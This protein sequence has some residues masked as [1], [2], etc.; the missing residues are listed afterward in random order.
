MLF[1]TEDRI[2]IKHYR[3]DKK[4]GSKPWSANGLDKF[5]EKIDDTG[6]KNRTNGSGR[7]KSLNPKIGHKTTLTRTLWITDFGKFDTKSV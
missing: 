3:L 5:I 1:T 4:Y 7:L 2:L 6:G